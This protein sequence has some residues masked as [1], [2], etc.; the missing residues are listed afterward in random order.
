MKKYIFLILIILLGYWYYNWQTDPQFGGVFVS[1][2]SVNNSI[3]SVAYISYDTC[4]SFKNCSLLS[5]NANVWG[6]PNYISSLYKVTHKIH[7]KNVLL[8]GDNFSYSIQHL[9]S[10]SAGFNKYRLSQMKTYSLYPINRVQLSDSVFTWRMTDNIDSF[11]NRINSGEGYAHN[12]RFEELYEIRNSFFL[13]SLVNTHRCNYI[14]F[15]STTS[16]SDE[17]ISRLKICR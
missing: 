6:R 14:E 3:D 7:L 17:F 12:Y 1:P 13:D 16:N 8:I 5:Y 15:I 9:I 10:R 2:V 4:F 11:Y